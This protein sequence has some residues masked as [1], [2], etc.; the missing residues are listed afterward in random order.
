MN[1]IDDKLDLSDYGAEPEGAE[2]ITPAWE[3]IAAMREDIG[4]PRPVG[5]DGVS[6]PWPGF[7]EM[8][9]LRDGEM[10]LWAGVNG[11]GK[12]QLTGM[13]AVDLVTARKK[14]CVVSLEMKPVDTLERMLRQFSGMDVTHCNTGDPREL[15]LM[16][17]AYMDFET[18]A[19]DLLWLYTQVGTANTTTIAKVARYCARKLG[20][21]HLFIDNLAKC[22]RGSDNYNAQKDFTDELFA[23]AKDYG[24]AIHLVHHIRK[25]ENEAKIPDKMDVKGAGE[26]ADIVDNIVVVWRNK[27]PPAQR[28]P[29]LNHDAVM[30]V[31][32]Q[33]HGPGW[34]GKIGLYYD[35]DSQ[36]YTRERGALIDFARRAA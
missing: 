2:D 5:R 34:E 20:I 11:H 31:V 21:Q 25:L 12:T 32:K 35:A 10:T 29:D 14:V 26:I 36:Q 9:R 23:I 30:S 28:K 24:M 22:I 19:N 3:L 8:F 18:Q 17:S 4:K 13:L 7:G 27:T 16:R 33:R 6:L 15:E 1:V